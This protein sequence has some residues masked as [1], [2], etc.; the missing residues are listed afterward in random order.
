MIAAGPAGVFDL[1]G[2]VAL[3]TGAAGG[4]GRF[5][6]QVL[7]EAGAHVVCSDVDADSLRET[8]RLVEQVGVR[9]VASVADVSSPEAVRGMV[10]G[11]VSVFGRLDVAV[12]NAGI[13][14]KPSRIHEISLDDWHRLIAI[15]LTGVFL[16]MREE[17]RVMVEQGGGV[18]INIASVAGLL[19]VE[20][21]LMPRAN[22]VA[23]KHGVIGLTKQAALEYAQ[24]GIR[25]NAIAPGWFSGT[26]LGRERRAS[27]SQGDAAALR[28]RRDEAIPMRRT[29]DI[30]ELR[31]LLLFL[32]SDAS[33]YV[34]GQVHVIDGGVCAH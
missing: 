6:S 10:D 4:F 29:G 9:A 33:S 11:A 1:S 15:D 16:C 19:G 2:K 30:S 34:T 7:A 32:A 18:V 14:T 5:F 12:N 21:A 17:L 13:V 31:G 23:A 22:Y 25:V 26:S 27:E 28:Q 24:D 20:P 8:V 3:V